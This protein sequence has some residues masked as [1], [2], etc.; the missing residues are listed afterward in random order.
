M[1][2]RFYP[3]KNFYMQLYIIIYESLYMIIYEICLYMTV[4]DYV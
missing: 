4:Y 3:S 2:Y 1:N